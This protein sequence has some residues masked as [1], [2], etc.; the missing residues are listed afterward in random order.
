MTA[1]RRRCVLVV[2]WCIMG[3]ALGCGSGN[4]GEKETWNCLLLDD[5]CT[6]SQP[7]PGWMPNPGGA[8]VERCPAAQCCLLSTVATDTTLA[9]CGCQTAADDCEARAA[10]SQ[11]KIVAICPPP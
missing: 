8:K 4:E 1:H 6:C 5:G 9:Y 7:R 2:G 11:A 10:A 3:L